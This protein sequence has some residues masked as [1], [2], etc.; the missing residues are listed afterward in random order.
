[1]AEMNMKLKQRNPQE[2]T[3]NQEITDKSVLPYCSYYL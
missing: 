3:S 1:M 2:A